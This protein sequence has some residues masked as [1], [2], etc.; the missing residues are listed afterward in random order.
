MIDV[1]SD[2]QHYYKNLKP[3]TSESLNLLNALQRQQMVDPRIQ[4][5]LV[6]YRD[7]LR[8]RLLVQRPYPLVHVAR[9]HHVRALP[10]AGRRH[11]VVHVR[12]QYGHGHVGLGHEIAQ[13]GGVVVGVEV[14]AAHA[15]E[16]GGQAVALVLLLAGDGDGDVPVAVQVFY[17]R[18]RHSAGAEDDDVLQGGVGWGGFVSA[19][20]GGGKVCFACVANHY[21]YKMI[22][23]NVLE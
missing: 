9:R 2:K 1:K 4:P 14:G 20:T 22:D 21:T 13:Q 11:H 19:S 8:R 5:D 15:F 6:E 7:P 10:H 12:G 23:S 18:G 16:L 3:L 17:E